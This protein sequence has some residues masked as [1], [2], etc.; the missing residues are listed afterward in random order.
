MNLRTA[1]IVSLLVT[2]IGGVLVWHGSTYYAIGNQQ[3]YEPAQPINFSHKL[4]A[5]DNQIQCLYCHSAAEKSPVAGIPAA[6]TCMNCHSQIRKDSPDVQKIAQ[7][8]AENR[9]I[10]W[11][12]I[13]DLPDHVA[14]NHSR[15][16][17]AG[18]KCQQCHGPIEAMDRVAQFDTLSMGMCVTCHRTHRE[19][20]LD[21]TGKPQ[22]SKEV[23]EA[24]L[25]ASTDC[26][27]C[28]H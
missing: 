4:H 7:A 13:H 10:E 17:T 14:F 24:R 16:V 15:H 23:S 28:H 22:I 2:L 12:R 8:V 3:G 26:S 18:I 9:P 11:V 27:V 20:T 5:G 1:K 19:V 25:M 21:P 6:A